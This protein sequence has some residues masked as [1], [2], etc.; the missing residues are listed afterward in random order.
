MATTTVGRDIYHSFP[1][2]ITTMNGRWPLF[3]GSLL[4][5]GNGINQI[6]LEIES[7]I[8]K[9]HFCDKTAIF[10]M[11]FS[12]QEVEQFLGHVFHEFGP[13]PF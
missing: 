4:M 10:S 8:C 1:Q 6:R 5:T 2:E 7:A 11:P 9:L 13:G 3:K 12:A